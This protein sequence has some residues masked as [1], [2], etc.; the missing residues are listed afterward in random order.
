MLY[1]KKI[2]FLPSQHG[3]LEINDQRA[4]AEMAE[5]RKRQKFNKSGTEGGSITRPGGAHRAD[6]SR[7]PPT[8]P[9][10]HIT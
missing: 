3:W 2:I 10:I 5:I 1:R 7:L 6:V 9:P 4:M 8:S